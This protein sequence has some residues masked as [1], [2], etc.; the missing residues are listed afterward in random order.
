MFTRE[1]FCIRGVQRRRLHP[2]GGNAAMGLV[3]TWILM[4]RA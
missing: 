4:L 1:E 3:E 2:L